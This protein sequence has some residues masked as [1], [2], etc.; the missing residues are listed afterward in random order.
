[1]NKVEICSHC[2]HI[3]TLNDMDDDFYTFCC[4]EGVLTVNKT[5]DLIV[6]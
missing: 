4:N 2:H 5:S 1:M 6:R 3:V